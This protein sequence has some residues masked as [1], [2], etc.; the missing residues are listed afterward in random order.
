MLEHQQPTASNRIL[1]TQ[2]LGSVESRQSNR[3]SPIGKES[4]ADSGRR[5]EKG[6]YETSLDSNCSQP[7]VLRP[8]NSVLERHYSQSSPRKD[9]ELPYR[10][11]PAAPEPLPEPDTP[12]VP[13]V[14]VTLNVFVKAN[15]AIN[16]FSP[17]LF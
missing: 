4:N 5:K 3:E 16:P 7:P 13:H 17:K 8:S 9:P 12:P 1:R 15:L 14:V 6:W 11:R 2:S 10:S